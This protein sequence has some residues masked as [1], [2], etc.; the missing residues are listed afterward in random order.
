MRLAI[1]EAEREAAQAHRDVV[2]RFEE[3][4]FLSWDET[5]EL[6][7]RWIRLLWYWSLAERLGLCPSAAPANAK[8]WQ[9]KLTRTPLGAPERITLGAVADLL[10]PLR[11]HPML[12]R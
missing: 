8:F 11:S 7:F 3:K 12:G 2:G 9:R 5:R 6:R 1:A 4:F 10:S